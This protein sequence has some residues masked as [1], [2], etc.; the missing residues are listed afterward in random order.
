[1]HPSIHVCA[2]VCACVCCGG[3][4]EALSKSVKIVLVGKYTALSDAY[5]SV[6]KSLRHACVKSNRKLDLVYVEAENL[7]DST[8]EVDPERYHQAWGKLCSGDGILVP[9]GFGIRGLEGKIAAIEWARTKQVPFLGI[10][11]G[12]QMAVIEHARNVL[13]WEGAHTTEADPNT[14]HPVIIDMPEISQT[15]MGGTQRLGKR[16]TVFNRDCVVKQMYGNVD[17]VDERHRHR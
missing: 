8:K 5:A 17:F 4:Y 6:V 11:L 13:K 15:I 9:G 3:R 16:R 7:E 12:F 1:M 2:F 14:P 10:C